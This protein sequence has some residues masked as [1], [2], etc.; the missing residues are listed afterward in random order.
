MNAPL[1]GR[2]NSSTTFHRLDVGRS[3]ETSIAT[4]CGRS[5]SH[6]SW[7]VS[8]SP[9]VDC[10][11]CI[12]AERR[13]DAARVKPKRDERGH[14]RCAFGHRREQDNGAAY[15]VD[16]V[17]RVVDCAV[18]GVRCA[19]CG[20]VVEAEV[21]EQDDLCPRCAGLCVDCGEAPGTERTAYDEPICEGCAEAR[22][23]CAKSGVE[24]AGARV[25]RARAGAEVWAGEETDIAW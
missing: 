17:G 24:P 20:D 3:T 22:W 5:A 10:R 4:L 13:R 25:M 19:A 1:A 9:D 8:P 14:W 6:E 23:A 12:G 11:D 2:L 7:Y 21:V 18:E 16:T 15:C